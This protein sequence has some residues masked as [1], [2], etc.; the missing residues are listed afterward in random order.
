MDQLASKL[1]DVKVT[2]N[3]NIQK[4]KP[5]SALQVNKLEEPIDLKVEK[6]KQVKK[7]NKTVLNF[8]EFDDDDNE[9]TCMLS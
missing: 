6:Q 4:K 3:V 8:S 1:N 2:P 7:E 5:T 9:P